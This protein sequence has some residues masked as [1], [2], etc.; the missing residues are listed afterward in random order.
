MLLKVGL[1]GHLRVLVN[2]LEGA[3]ENLDEAIQ[4]C[5]RRSKLAQA[6]TCCECLSLFSI[7][8]AKVGSS[9]LLAGTNKDGG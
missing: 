8:N 2:L 4:V 1:N 3:L 9:T 7:R 5:D 6:R